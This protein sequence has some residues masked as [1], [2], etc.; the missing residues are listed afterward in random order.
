M[1]DVQTLKKSILSFL[2]MS[3]P[4]LPIHVARYTKQS[5]LFTGAFLSELIA[6]NKVKTSFMKIGGSPLYFLP[7]QERK[8]EPFGEHLKDKEKEAFQL[9]KRNKVLVHDEQ[10][11]AI[12]VALKSIKDFAFT[13]EKDG[14]V[15]WRYFLISDDE[16]RTLFNSQKGIA[17]NEN[18]KVH[19][20]II[21]YHQYQRTAI[22]IQR[23]QTEQI[24]KRPIIAQV[25]E[26]KKEPESISEGIKEPVNEKKHIIK[27]AVKKKSNQIK[28]DKFFDSIKD[29][30][31]SKDYEILD[32]INLSKSELTLLIEKDKKKKMIAAFNK[33]SVSEPDIIK[34]YK[35]AKE[36]GLPYIVLSKGEPNKKIKNFVEAVKSLEEIGKI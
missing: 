27:T 5:M 12:R 29:I 20:Q 35:K 13:T 23:P 2:D 30:L 31:I 16:A 11:P 22:N 14:K 8:L 33:K 9:L 19:P 6:E 28:N 34:A 24:I 21:P 15:N 17:E 4:S 26:N 7:G 36:L 18:I 25:E 32:I 1:Q 3:G 10:N